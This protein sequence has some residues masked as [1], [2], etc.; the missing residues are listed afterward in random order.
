MTGQPC[1]SY[2]TSKAAGRSKDKPGS[3]E[4]NLQA[5][6]ATYAG[7]CLGPLSGPSSTDISI[8]C[9]AAALHIVQGSVG[10]LAKTTELTPYH[11]KLNKRPW[12]S[13]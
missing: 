1:H 5:L 6:H 9:E 13:V 2:D 12:K 4:E 8:T 10:T 7:R 3:K 11:I